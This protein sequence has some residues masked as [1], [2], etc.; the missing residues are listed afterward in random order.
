VCQFCVTH[1]LQ[2]IPGFHDSSH[3][4]ALRWDEWRIVSLGRLDG[5]TQSSRYIVDSCSGAQQINSQSV[6]ESVWM[7]VP[8][9]SRFA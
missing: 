3:S 8:D 6:S 7:R 4:V 2:P 5:I 9:T 1:R